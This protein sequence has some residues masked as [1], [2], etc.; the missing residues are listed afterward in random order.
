[1]TSGAFAIIQE[2]S[3]QCSCQICPSAF[4]L[5]QIIDVII[6]ILLLLVQ[7]HKFDK[8]SEKRRKRISTGDD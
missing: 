6:F 4:I 5:H 3:T 2:L 8:F 1:M 7:I